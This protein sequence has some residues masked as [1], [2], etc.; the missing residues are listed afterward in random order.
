MSSGRSCLNFVIVGGGPTGVELAGAIADIAQYALKHEFRHINPA[1]AHIML[2]EAGDR[3]LGEL[4][5]GALGQGAGSARK[6]RR[7]GPA[8]TRR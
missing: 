7:E 4:S 1:D 2:V 8:R 3:M 6:A 5:A